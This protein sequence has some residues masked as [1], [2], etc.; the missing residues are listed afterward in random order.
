MAGAR[1]SNSRERSSGNN[2]R[3]LV[4][5]AGRHNE[6]ERNSSCTYMDRSGRTHAET[7]PAEVPRLRRTPRAA[8][9]EQLYGHCVLLAGG[10]M[11]RRAAV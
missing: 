4:A 5:A 2:H 1:R 11:H 10:D 3:E 6:R 7:V 8:L 9:E